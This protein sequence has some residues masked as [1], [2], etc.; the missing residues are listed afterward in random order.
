VPLRNDSGRQVV[1]GDQLGCD[2]AQGYYVGHPMPAADFERW[3]RE[4]HLAGARALV[5]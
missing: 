2:I 1:A 4:E 5:A 3:L